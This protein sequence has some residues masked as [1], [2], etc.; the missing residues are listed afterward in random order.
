[1]SSGESSMR[2]TAVVAKHHFT[3][4]QSSNRIFWES[5]KTLPNT[6]LYAHPINQTHWASWRPDSTVRTPGGRA[7]IGWAL[8]GCRHS[9]IGR[10]TNGMRNLCVAPSD[11]LF[12]RPCRKKA[13]KLRNLGIFGR[14]L[15]SKIQCFA[16]VTEQVI[17]TS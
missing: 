15:G 9:L 11:V 5:K 12:G 1:M 3:S 13:K 2:R 4:V 10:E 6:V 14:F 8:S 17:S 16:P 7:G